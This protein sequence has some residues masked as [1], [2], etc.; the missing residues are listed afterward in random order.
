MTLS[1]AVNSMQVLSQLGTYLVAMDVKP[2]RTKV[3]ERD[4][5]DAVGQCITCGCTPDDGESRK[6]GNCDR[7]YQDYRTARQALPE[8]K[9]GQFDAACIRDCKLMPDRQGQRLNKVNEFK[10]IANEVKE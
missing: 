8:D 5:R 1:F 10:S 6:R 4:R 9:R 3:A 2:I 7:C